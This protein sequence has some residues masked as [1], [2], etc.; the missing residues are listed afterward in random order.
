MAVG[1]PVADPGG[2]C[3]RE[4]RFGA[5]H[6]VGEGLDGLA[7]LDKTDSHGVEESKISP[8]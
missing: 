6:V 2:L 8:S 3:P 4:C 5:E 7:D 1:K